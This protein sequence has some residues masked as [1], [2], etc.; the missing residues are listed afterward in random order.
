MQEHTTT[1]ILRAP[2]YN[3]GLI[4]LVVTFCLIQGLYFEAGHLHFVGIVEY[5]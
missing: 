2:D 3:P 1:R 4:Q 5:F